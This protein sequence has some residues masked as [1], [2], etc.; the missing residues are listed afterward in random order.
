[1]YACVD[2]R[3]GL[4]MDD[5]R[6]VQPANLCGPLN[7]YRV[8]SCLLAICHPKDLQGAGMNIA[9]E[10]TVLSDFAEARCSDRTRYCCINYNIFSRVYMY[11]T[12]NEG[13]QVDC[14]ISAVVK[15]EL[16]ICHEPLYMD[17]ASVPW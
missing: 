9:F 1:M 3:S 4:N 17:L 11:T 16:I 5:W 7:L 14:G 10:D 8:I 15:G 2:Y 13:R 6:C 12:R